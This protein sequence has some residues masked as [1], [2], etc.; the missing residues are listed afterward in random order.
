MSFREIENDIKSGILDKPIPILIFGDEPFLV[1]HYENQLISIFSG[2]TPSPL[3]ISVFYGDSHFE[4][5]HYVLLFLFGYS[6]H[7]AEVESAIPTRRPSPPTHSNVQSFQ[8]HPPR[9]AATH[10][11]NSEHSII[12]V[13]A[14]SEQQT[15]HRYL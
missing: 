12:Q 2:E 1:A 3:D 13:S 7:I 8:A 5:K 15:A 10:N 9:G 11:Y 14:F 4:R 6:S